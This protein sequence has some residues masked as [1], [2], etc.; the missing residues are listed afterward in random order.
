MAAGANGLFLEVHPDP[1]NA[2]S[3]AASVLPLDWLEELI[4]VCSKI[5]RVVHG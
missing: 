2:K 4:V 5:H 3:D 1:E